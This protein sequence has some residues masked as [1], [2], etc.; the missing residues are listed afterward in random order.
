MGGADSGADPTPHPPLPTLL[1]SPLHGGGGGGGGKGLLRI[2]SCSGA[3]ELCTDA[4]SIRQR[5][6]REES[7]APVAGGQLFQR[8]DRAFKARR[9]AAAESPLP[10]SG[11]G[12]WALRSPPLP[13]APALFLCQA[14]I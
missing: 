7:K 10:A 9:G 12:P 3:H 13:N 4:R 6:V 5:P 14:R 8:G 2:H 1:P 11:P